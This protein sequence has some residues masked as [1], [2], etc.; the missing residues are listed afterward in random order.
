MLTITELEK[1]LE[2]VAR[3]IENEIGIRLIPV[4]F[5]MGSKKTVVRYGNG[6]KAE[7]RGDRVKIWTKEGKHPD[8]IWDVYQINRYTFW[9]EQR[10]FI[11]GT[12]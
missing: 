7:I 12:V 9:G 5:R 6:W 11:S 4:S 3:G 10:V 1:I 2:A 8:P